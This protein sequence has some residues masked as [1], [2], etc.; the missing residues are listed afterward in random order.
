MTVYVSEFGGFAPGPLQIAFTPGIGT[1]YVI[2][3]TTSGVN[4]TRAFDNATN[5]IRVHTDGICSIAMVATTTAAA[6]AIT[7]MRMPANT[8]EYFGVKPGYH[9]SV[10]T[11]S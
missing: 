4:S 5:Y 9:V 1:D 3:P 2:T 7:N 10:I 8:T 11:N 6:A